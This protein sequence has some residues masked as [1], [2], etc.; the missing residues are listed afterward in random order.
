MTISE[1]FILGLV[2]L[3]SY[4]VV[5]KL[6]AT[7]LKSCDRRETY[8][9]Q[10]EVIK[11]FHSKNAL[12]E[13]VF[14]NLD[15]LCECSNLDIVLQHCA[16]NNAILE[17]DQHFDTF[18][19]KCIGY[20]VI[21]YPDVHYVLHHDLTDVPTRSSKRRK[22]FSPIPP[23][24]PNNPF[25]KNTTTETITIDGVECKVNANTTAREYQTSLVHKP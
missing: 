2:F 19:V 16:C 22:N 25:R 7:N 10:L 5:R 1:I 21:I 18:K 23:E 20:D 24:N 6:F 11:F 15:K 8:H 17:W 13:F 9:T 3:I 14:D 4:E 12:T